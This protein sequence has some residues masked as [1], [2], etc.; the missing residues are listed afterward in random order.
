MELIKYYVNENY[1]D[2]NFFKFFCCVPHNKQTW[3]DNALR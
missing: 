3:A 2:F 1:P